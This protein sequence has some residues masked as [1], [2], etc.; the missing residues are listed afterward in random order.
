MQCCS[1]HS[2][3]DRIP[4]PIPGPLPDGTA[5]EA[6]SCLTCGSKPD[7]IFCDLDRGCISELDQLR[8]MN[9]YPAGSVV[10]LAGEQPKGVYCVCAGKLKVWRSSPEGRS[11]T[12]GFAAAGD[13]LGARSLLLGTTHDLSSEA[14]EP[15]KLCFIPQVNFLGYL[16]RNGEVSLRLAEKLS[17]ELAVAYRQVCGV[18]LMPTAER[19]AELLLSL[20]HVHGERT[21]KGVELKANMRQD[22]LAEMV[23]ASR[24]SLSRALGIL[25]GHGLIECRRRFIIVRD[26]I[27]LQNWLI[28]RL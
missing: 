28:P 24:R 21:P 26:F 18:V 15:T 5:P 12:L 1:K 6:E 25:K 8:R 2:I 23:G 20:C 4:G 16:K 27:A 11:V 22:E 7:S 13:I 9:F 3:K 14:V 10:F 17:T 19:L